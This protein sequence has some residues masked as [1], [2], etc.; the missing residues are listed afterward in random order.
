[1]WQKDKLRALDSTKLRSDL[2][3]PSIS[4]QANDSWRRS[5]LLC[6]GPRSRK[7]SPACCVE[8]SNAIIV[9][10]I[11]TLRIPHTIL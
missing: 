5:S 4:E 6:A 10:A 3:A 9:S 8:K 1:M 2:A 7:F 11:T